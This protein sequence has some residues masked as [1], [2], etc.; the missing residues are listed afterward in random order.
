[1]VASPLLISDA[2]VQGF[3]DRINNPYSMHAFESALRHSTNTQI[4][5]ENLN[6]IG[7][8]GISTLIVWGLHD[9]VI[10]TS[11]SEIFKNAIKDSTVIVIPRA[12][13]APF[14]EKP[15]LVCEHLH[16]FLADK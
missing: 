2:L 8:N 3:I 16:K 15:A 4:G 14:T 6:R 11:H 13:H 9:K 7:Q 1:M 12:G 10:P 5:L